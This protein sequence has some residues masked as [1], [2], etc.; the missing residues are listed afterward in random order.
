MRAMHV[1]V[2]IAVLAAVAGGGTAAAQGV[3]VSVGGGAAPPLGYL[4]S[5]ANTG[6]H[7]LAAV[8]VA[9]SAVPVSIRLDAMYSRFD[10]SGDDGHFRVVQGTVNAV[11]RFRAAEATTIRPYLIGGLG[12]YNYKSIFDPAFFQDNANT[13]L[14]INGGAGATV[15]LGGLGVFAEVRYH[16]V[17][18]SGENAE[19]L[20]ITVGVQLGGR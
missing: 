20:P 11:Y 7:G 14:G 15:M 2:V 13:D 3:T 18:T 4:D 10:F 5:G 16:G 12:V 19:F 1:L 17:F 9:P 8:T 6:I